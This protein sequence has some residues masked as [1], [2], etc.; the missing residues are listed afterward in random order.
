M[1]SGPSPKL[2][3]K[4]EIIEVPRS[5][6][7]NGAPSKQFVA[8]AMFQGPLPPP[9][10]LAK[11]EAAWPGSAE[12]IVKMAEDEAAHR[13]SVE[14]SIVHAR[15]EGSNKDFMEA[16]L[17]Q[18]FALVITLTALSLGA[19]VALQGH[20]ITG[21]IIGAGGFGSIVTAF[22]LGKNRRSD[23]EQDAPKQNAQQQKQGNSRKRRGK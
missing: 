16:R 4:P 7:P 22:I 6:S 14:N 15:R 12:R 13:R 11:Y 3:V 19:Y 2:P 21:G 23:D 20:E 1:S 18:I 17:G 8:A 10:L 5:E 9:E